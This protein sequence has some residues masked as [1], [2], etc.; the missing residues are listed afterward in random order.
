VTIETKRKEIQMALPLDCSPPLSIPGTNSAELRQEFSS[1]E[2]LYPLF[3][4]KMRLAY[5]PGSDGSTCG[6]CV[7]FNRRR[8]CRAFNGQFGEW[9][10]TWPGCG[11]FNVRQE[12]ERR[13]LRTRIWDNRNRVSQST[14]TPEIV[15]PEVA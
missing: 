15:P 4:G 13:N 14:G 5:G 7:N 8:R 3:A 11:A 2:R 10:P 9:D 6:K 12:D 1:P